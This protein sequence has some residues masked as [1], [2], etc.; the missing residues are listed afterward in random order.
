MNILRHLKAFLHTIRAWLGSTKKIRLAVVGSTASGK[1]YLLTDVVGSLEKLGFKR[2]DR[3]AN[4]HLQRDVYSLFEEVE[5]NGAI[6]KSLVKACRQADVY[7][8]RF[9]DRN[10]K[11]VLVE[12][13]DVPGEV[14]VPD[15]L[16]LFRSLMKAL[17]A[18]REPIFTS[19]R[20]V[21]DETGQAVLLVG[22]RRGIDSNGPIGQL[23]GWVGSAHLRQ[24]THDSGYESL[25]AREAH[26]K[27]LGFVPKKS[28]KVNG[29]RLFRDFLDYDTDTVVQAIIHAWG[30]LKVDSVLPTDL[31]QQGGGSGKPL[32]AKNYKNHFFY[33]YFTFHAT[34]IIVCDKCCTPQT[35]GEAPAPSDDIFPVMMASLKSMTQYEDLPPKNWYL[36]VKGV[37]ALMQE[38]PFRHVYELSGDYN[39][40][41][42]HFTAL[43][44]QACLHH[45]WDG[46]SAYRPPFTSDATMMQWLTGNR[47]LDGQTDLVDLLSS[48][49][50]QLGTGIGAL[51]KGDTDYRMESTMPLADHLSSRFA[52][53]VQ[54]DHRLQ[55]D[56][57]RDDEVMLLGMPRHVF[58]VATPIDV[59]LHICGHEPSSPTSFEGRAKYYNQRADFGTLQLLTAIM[60]RHE[61]SIDINRHIGNIGLLLTDSMGFN[62]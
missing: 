48:H 30:E 8:S 23:D 59:D 6:G 19:T 37:D 34:D 49:Y 60:T 43:L 62:V 55:N 38:E 16:R 9:T 2:D 3:Y 39:L 46:D 15:S 21:N 14:M 40:V 28:K 44:R 50:L 7:L 45:L 12:F 47:Q 17:M 29:A 24:A 57:G 13:I 53:F 41:Y 35:A 4:D 42:S 33:H 58:F 11:G 20:W 22:V 18:C 31:L 5:S 36:A 26:Y 1:T 51:L 32:F 10:D 25:A 52:H 27:R 54:A 61:M 56:K